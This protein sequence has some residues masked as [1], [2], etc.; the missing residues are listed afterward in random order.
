MKMST[1]GNWITRAVLAFSGSLAFSFLFTAAASPDAGAALY[2]TKCVACHGPDGKGATPVG[3]ADGIRDLGSVGVQGQSDS[4][5]TSIITSG[6]SKMPGYGKSLKPEQ[7]TALVAY[8]RSLAS[9]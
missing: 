4:V 2:R 3:K 7:I 1:H 9:K 5:L 6:K 8:V